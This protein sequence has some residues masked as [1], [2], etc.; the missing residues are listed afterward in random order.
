MLVESGSVFDLDK[1]ATLTSLGHRHADSCRSI[2]TMH[3][4]VV[5][6]QFLLNERVVSSSACEG[7]ANTEAAGG[8][9]ID[10]CRE[11]LGVIN[12]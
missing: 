5:P 6:M 7:E 8:E 3:H 1:E 4:R 10:A 11:V 2:L 12:I 9:A